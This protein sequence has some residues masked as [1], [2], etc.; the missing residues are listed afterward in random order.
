MLLEAA[1]F[2]FQVAKG[3][4]LLP[5]SS[6]GAGSPSRFPSALSPGQA[7]ANLSAQPG[8]RCFAQLC[9]SMANGTSATENPSHNKMMTISDCGSRSA[10]PP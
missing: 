10:V 9:V 2:R 3:D 7:R 4:G 1:E 5:P 6:P 8:G